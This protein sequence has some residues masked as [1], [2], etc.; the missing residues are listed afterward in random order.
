MEQLYKEL[1]NCIVVASTETNTDD[2]MNSFIEAAKEV[3][4]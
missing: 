1:D 4:R 3:L 2:D